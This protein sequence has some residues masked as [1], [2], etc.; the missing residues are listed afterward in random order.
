MKYLTTQYAGSIA[1]IIL[2]SLD[3]A[4]YED[5][6]EIIPGLIQAVL[7]VSEGDDDLLNE[8]ANFLADGGEK[9]EYN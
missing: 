7:D 6:R 5:P 8:A 2:D 1:D 3:E 4:G 9:S